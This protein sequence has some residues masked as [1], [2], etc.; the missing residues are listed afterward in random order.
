MAVCKECGGERFDLIMNLYTE[1][2]TLKNGGIY[3]GKYLDSDYSQ[4]GAIWQCR[5]CKRVFRYRG[6][7]WDADGKLPPNEEK[8]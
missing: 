7:G 6:Y 4:T 5:T 8:V 3:I 2:F 1:K